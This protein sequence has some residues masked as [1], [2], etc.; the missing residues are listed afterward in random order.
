MFI[1]EVAAA[2]NSVSGVNQKQGGE[3]VQLGYL[4]LDM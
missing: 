4:R 2:R 3:L 1:T